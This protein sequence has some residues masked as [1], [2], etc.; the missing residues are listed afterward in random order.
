MQFEL[1]LIPQQT[2]AFVRVNKQ[3]GQVVVR[4]DA[5]GVRLDRRPGEDRFL[6]ALSQGFAELDSV[7]PELE[8]TADALRGFG[9]SEAELVLA[10]YKSHVR[11]RW[12]NIRADGP[13]ELLAA[14]AEAIGDLPEHWARDQRLVTMYARD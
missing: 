14:H 10:A 6:G 11:S 3:T 8:L 7:Q 1:R 13:R 12:P 2:N 9:R 5:P 4:A